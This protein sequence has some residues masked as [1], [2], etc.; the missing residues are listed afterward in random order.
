MFRD[1]KTTTSIF[2]DL[3]TRVLVEMITKSPDTEE[4]ATNLKHLEKLNELKTA[5]NPRRSKLDS[6]TILLVAGNLIGILIIVGYEHSN[7]LGS[8]AIGFVKTLS[9]RTSQVS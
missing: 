5:E 2:D 1:R 3:I 8:K 9:N 6:N 7:V 4:Y